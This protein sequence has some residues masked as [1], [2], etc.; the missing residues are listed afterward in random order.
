MFLYFSRNNS[1]NITSM[2]K[3]MSILCQLQNTFHNKMGTKIS[4]PLGALKIQLF[5][6]WHNIFLFSSFYSRLWN[7]HAILDCKINW[8]FL[9]GTNI[10]SS[11]YYQG[12]IFDCLNYGTMAERSKALVSGTSLRARVFLRDF[13]SRSCQSFDFQSPWFISAS[14]M[15]SSGVESFFKLPLNQR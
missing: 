14:V 4:S 7:A 12:M 13:E 11:F 1:V 5:V 6:M 15:N 2:E 10:S 3:E 9:S 8:S